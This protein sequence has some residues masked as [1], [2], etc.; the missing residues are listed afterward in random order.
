MFY[1]RRQ[2]LN[3]GLLRINKYGHEKRLDDSSDGYLSDK[4]ILFIESDR[5]STALVSTL[6][7]PALF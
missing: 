1:N 3:G 2:G 4:N 6:I 5:R 7:E